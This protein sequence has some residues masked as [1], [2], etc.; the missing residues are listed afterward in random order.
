M[1]SRF[2]KSNMPGFTIIELMVVVAVM[3]ILAGIALPSY[4]TWMRSIQI[5]NAGES[6]VNGLQKARGEAISRNANVKF[7]LGVA[8]SWVVGCQT[9]TASCPATI[10]SRSSNDGSKDVTVTPSPAG[11]T[12]VT[13][14]NFGRVVANNNASASISSID[15]S[16]VD[17]GKNM[18]V[19][20]GL[21]GNAKM[22]DP[23]LTAGTSP[24]AC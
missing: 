21:G 16:V 11:T 23:S 24:Q 1:L 12:M 3:S 20:I 14:N 17:G 10:D 4:N 13:F 6:I 8:S 22:C 7:T 18:Q 5:R 9:V 2:P 15:L 19:S